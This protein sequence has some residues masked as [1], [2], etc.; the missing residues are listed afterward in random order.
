MPEAYYLA[1]EQAGA[2]PQE[3]VFVDDSPRNLETAR[4]IGITPV[5]LAS[6]CPPAAGFHCIDSLSA[7][8]QLLSRL[9]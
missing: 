5:L 6:S 9:G 7:L 1:L 3:S 2:A 8:P 4:E